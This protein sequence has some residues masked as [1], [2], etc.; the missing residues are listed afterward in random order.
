[1]DADQVPPAMQRWKD[2]PSAAQF[3]SPTL[4]EPD[5]PVL[6]DPV[7]GVPDVPVPT[8]AAAVVEEAAAEGCW[9]AGEEAPVGADPDP[10]TVAKP[11]PTDCEMELLAAGLETTVLGV[12]P[13]AEGATAE[14]PPPAEGEDDPEEEPQLPTGGPSLAPE[15]TSSELP[16]LGYWTSTPSV[17]EHPLPTLPMLA[18][19]RSGRGAFCRLE[20]LAGAYLF[21]DAAESLTRAQFMYISRFPIL[22]CQVQARV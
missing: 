10:E 14:L 22:L 17:V 15:P 19:K 9:A 20:K 18:L 3:Q 8:G 6:G 13:V 12:V 16:G 4:Q 5:E 7:L 1:M 11:P 21:F 2:L